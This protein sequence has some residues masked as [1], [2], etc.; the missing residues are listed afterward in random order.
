[1]Q[2]AA[3]L[4]RRALNSNATPRHGSRGRVTPFVVHAWSGWPWPKHSEKK[5]ATS[6]VHSETTSFQRVH[7]GEGSVGVGVE[8][9]STPTHA[10]L[11]NNIVL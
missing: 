6:S 11:H 2:R 8:D 10:H 4:Q 9:F 7:G 3:G 1:M 5:G